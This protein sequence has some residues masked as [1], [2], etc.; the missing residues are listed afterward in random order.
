MTGQDGERKTDMEDSRKVM[1]RLNGIGKVYRLGQIGNG[2]LQSDLQSWWAK[3]R[4][5]EDPNA[6]IGQVRRL[7]GDRFIA[8]ENIDSEADTRL[9][10]RFLR[11]KSKKESLQ[12][13]LN[14]N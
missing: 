11:S 8:L 10:E 13:M 3:V 1:I 5:K 9:R 6:M 4:G 12:D 2:T 7:E 14:H